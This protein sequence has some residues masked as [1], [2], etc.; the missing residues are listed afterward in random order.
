MGRENPPSLYGKWIEWEW[1]ENN[2]WRIKPVPF[3]CQY[4]KNDRKKGICPDTA[5]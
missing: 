4:E 5:L 3:D 1:F 2:P